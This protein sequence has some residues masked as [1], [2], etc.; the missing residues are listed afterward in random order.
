MPYRPPGS[1]YKGAG[2]GGGSRVV[3]LLGPDDSKVAK[4]PKVKAPGKIK[5][6]KP[7]KVQPIQ[8]TS[9]AGAAAQMFAGTSSKR[10]RASIGGKVGYRSGKVRMGSTAFYEKGY[11]Q[12]AAQ[13]MANVLANF[14][15][16]IGRLNQSSADAAYEALLPA[17]QLSQ[18]YVPYR[19]GLLSDSGKIDIDETSAS[20]RAV[21]SYGDASTGVNYAAIVH[22][23]TY[24]PHAPP[25]RAKYLQAAF[26]ETLGEMYMRFVL[27]LR[28]AMEG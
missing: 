8:K 6:T 21:I 25:T 10:N 9:S 28:P 2:G 7:Y 12:T 22:E 27:A 17:F 13:G 23:L 4:A 14:N 20:P 19:T 18:V 3:R 24:I 16:L 1:P 15:K 5:S 11:S 26:E